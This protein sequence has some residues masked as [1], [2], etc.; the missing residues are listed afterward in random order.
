VEVSDAPDVGPAAIDREVD[1]KLGRHLGVG[2]DLIA[3]EVHDDEVLRLG[4]VAET[5]GSNQ[6]SFRRLRAGTDVAE[7]VDESAAVQE[8]PGL[9]ELLRKE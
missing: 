6:D 7:S 3:V 2:F 9:V 5:V 4:V 8:P 1:R